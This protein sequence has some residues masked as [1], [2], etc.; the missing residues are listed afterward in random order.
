M[1][2]QEQQSSPGSSMTRP[3]KQPAEP[4]R[5]WL[6]DMHVPD[7]DLPLMARLDPADYVR[8]VAQAGFQSLLTQA[9]SHVGLCY[10]RTKLGRMHANMKGR[11]YL[12]EV[13]TECRRHGLQTRAYYSLVFDNWA[14]ESHP[15]W[16]ILPAAG[17][18]EILEG[19]YGAVCPNSPYR[20]QTLASLRE[21]VGDYD[22]DVIWLDMIFWPAV[23]YCEH[24]T[25][26]FWREYKAEPPTT[27]D[28]DD[29]TW[30]SF[31]KARQ[32]WLLYFHEVVTTTIKET[33]PISV[34]HQSARIFSP[35]NLGW[36]P[37]ITD[38]TTYLSGDMAGL[39]SIR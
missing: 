35:W 8:A 30:K 33:R 25:A 1:Q 37:E 12:G 22:F 36:P 16:R 28:W 27:V 14:F 24:C 11:D 5:R 34:V 23:C 38:T 29:P 26:R 4:Y 20:E 7:W 10:Y 19:R 32:Q 39:R 3:V 15:D 21:L 17:Y 9:K 18:G 2:A 6:M 13:L 31:Q